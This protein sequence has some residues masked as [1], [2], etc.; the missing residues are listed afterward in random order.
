[1]RFFQDVLA[2]NFLKVEVKFYT[3]IRIQQLKRIQIRF[4]NF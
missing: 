1:M 3:Q 2:L 4:H